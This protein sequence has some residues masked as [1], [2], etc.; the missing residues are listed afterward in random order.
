MEK[1]NLFYPA[2]IKIYI[3]FIKTRLESA[4]PEV[5]RQVKVY[6]D[7]LKTGKLTDFPKRNPLFN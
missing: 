4:M 7:K 2:D 6:E 5:H 3:E 1:E